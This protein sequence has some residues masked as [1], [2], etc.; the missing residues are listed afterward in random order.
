MPTTTIAGL[1]AL[2]LLSFAPVRLKPDATSSVRIT[3]ATTSSVPVKPD[4]TSSVRL[5]PDTTNS[6]PVKPDTT[7]SVRMTPAATGQE[8]VN[9]QAAVLQE[10]KQRVDEY[11]KLHNQLEKESPPLKKTDDPAKIKAS[12]ETLAA[13]LRTARAQA[14]PGEI[15]TPAVQKEFRRL[16]RPEVTGPESA[17]TKKA[18][19]DDQPAKV[20]LKVNA[21]YPPDQPLPSVP[22]Q[23][24]LNLPKLPED[25]EFRIIGNHLILRDVHANIIVDFMP[26]VIPQTEER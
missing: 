12:Q 3:P 20:T 7:N 17:D 6:V 15:F 14:K 18:I 25:L 1:I 26:R 21:I 24:L 10:F 2:A 23:I 8:K 5:K 4:A 16:L 22:P 13:K 19:K 9:P 11:M